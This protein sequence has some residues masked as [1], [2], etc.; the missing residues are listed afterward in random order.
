[1]RDFYYNTSRT[2]AYNNTS[3]TESN[4]ICSYFPAASVG[5]A[6]ERNVFRCCSR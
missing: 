5:T 6:E 4:V 1:M 3:W 2:A